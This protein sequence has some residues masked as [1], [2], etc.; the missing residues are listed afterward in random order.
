MQVLMLYMTLIFSYLLD[1]DFIDDRAR[2]ASN[3]RLESLEN[4]RSR[5]NNPNI[6]SVESVQSSTLSLNY[7]SGKGQLDTSQQSTALTTL[8]D[9]KD[10]EEEQIDDKYKQNFKD[11]KQMLWAWYYQDQ[12][13]ENDWVQF[14]CSECLIIEFEYQAYK[15][16]QDEKYRELPIG[17]KMPGKVRFDGPLLDT[18]VLFSNMNFQ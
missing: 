6:G 3:A 8:L 18:A 4:F 1:A 10:K 17:G 15:L 11:V 5:I 7:N 9:S 14:D 2:V 16:S 12:D 13:K